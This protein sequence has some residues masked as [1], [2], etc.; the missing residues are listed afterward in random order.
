MHADLHKAVAKPFLA[1]F[2][3]S[4]IQGA[5]DDLMTGDATGWIPGEPERS[6]S[7]GLYSRAKIARLYHSASPGT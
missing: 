1:R 2:T 5:L 7:A 6:P 4:D 3:A